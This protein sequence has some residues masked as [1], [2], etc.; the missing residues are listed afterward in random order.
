[1][2]KIILFFDARG[3]KCGHFVIFEMVFPFLESKNLMKSKPHD[4]LAAI[5]PLIVTFLVVGIDFS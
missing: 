5:G 4:G 3:L 2:V 1:M